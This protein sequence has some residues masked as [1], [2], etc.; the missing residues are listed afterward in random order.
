MCDSGDS[1]KVKCWKVSVD[2]ENTAWFVSN[3]TGVAEFMRVEMEGGDDTF[4]YT[5]E[6]IEM[7][8]DE[9]NNLGE[10]DGW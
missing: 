7:D 9:Y 3:P 4:K 5:I 1:P 10:F 2:D 8:E 6:Q